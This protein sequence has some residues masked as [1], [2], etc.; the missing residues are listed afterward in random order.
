[1]YQYPGVFVRDLCGAV[2]VVAAVQL[3]VGQRPEGLQMTDVPLVE[4]MGFGGAVAFPGTA[5]ALAGQ[6]S[7]RPRQDYEDDAGAAAA[8]AVSVGGA[9]PGT[10]SGAWDPRWTPV[11]TPLRD[12]D[13]GSGGNG[14][15]DDSDNAGLSSA[16]DEADEGANDDEEEGGAEDGDVGQRDGGGG[17]VD[18][19]R[20]GFSDADGADLSNF[21]ARS[22]TP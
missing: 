16:T 13:A 2:A 5:A 11:G 17:R 21:S 15:D 9:A 4:P 3:Q 7:K 20:T 12:D 18:E 1:M 19:S 22:V 14:G 6:V 10:V 8:A